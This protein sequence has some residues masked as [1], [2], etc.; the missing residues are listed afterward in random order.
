MSSKNTNLI[1]V[2]CLLSGILLCILGCNAIPS[3]K[4]ALA[5]DPNRF[6]VKSMEITM[7]LDQREEFFTQLQN[8]ADKHSLELRSTF[9]DADKKGFL[10]VLAGD[11]FDISAISTLHY[12]REISVD[13]YNE[14]SPPTP[15]A[16]FD[17][18]SLDLKNFLNKIPNV[19][20]KEKLKRLRITMDE[21][22][23]EEV[24]TKLFTQLREFANQ[25]SLKFIVSSYNADMKIF[26]VE[27]QGE[28]FQITSEVV[29]SGPGEIN[30]DFY[31]HYDDK[32]APTSTSQKTVDELFSDLKNF[33]SKIPNVTITEEK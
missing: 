11:G 2:M 14:A 23:S 33:F 4:K 19:I 13:F 15:Q 17:E 21:N 26:L 31:I 9:Y 8:F 20:I 24:F 22:Q 3:I 32:G 30:V 25:H 12:P 16:T 27:M 7:D 10:I 1:S 6:P 28:G 29:R 18:L 5:P